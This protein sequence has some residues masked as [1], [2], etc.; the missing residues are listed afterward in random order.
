VLTF[1]IIHIR[2]NNSKNHYLAQ[3]YLQVT[4]SHD[5]CGSIMRFI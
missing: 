1:Q 2:L 5:A 3:P 4:T